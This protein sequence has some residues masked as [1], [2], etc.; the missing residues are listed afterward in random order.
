M[1]DIL[2]VLVSD[3]NRSNGVVLPPLDEWKV[4]HAET[5]LWLALCQLCMPPRLP[6]FQGCF[7]SGLFCVAV[8]HPPRP[9]RVCFLTCLVDRVLFFS[10]G[11]F[12]LGEGEMSLEV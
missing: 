1:Q 7:A 9:V 8:I 3:L 4:R 10:P 12:Y 2:K 6:W 5:P 11:T